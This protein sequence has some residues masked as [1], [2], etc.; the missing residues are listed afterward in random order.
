MQIIF[1]SPLLEA[2]LLIAIGFIVGIIN[3]IS[4]GGSTLTLPIL[5]FLGLDA[6]TA[7]GTN[8]IAILTQNITA[9]AG[10]KSKGIKVSKISW[11]LGVSALI[12]SLIG[13]KIAIDVKDE[14]FNRILAVVMI[15]IVG[16]MVFKPKRSLDE[17]AER[18][19]GK[20]FWMSLVA[21]F[22]IGIYGGFIQAGTGILMMLALSFINNMSLVKTNVVKA[23]T[24]LIYTIATLMVFWLTDNLNFKYGLLMAIGQAAGGWL[25][26]RWSVDKGDGFVKLFLIL[27]VIV[28]AVKLWFF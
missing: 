14:T 11:W 7:N 22:F 10:F 26:S 25:S 27:M 2:G 16:L 4:G 15:F 6:P 21:F 5:I 1:M 3:T 28:M 20:Y 13:A 19:T 17:I 12:G 18:L 23:V 9:I 24:M 8:R